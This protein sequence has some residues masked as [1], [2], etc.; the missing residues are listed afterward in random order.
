[1]RLLILSCRSSPMLKYKYIVALSLVSTL[2]CAVLKPVPTD[3]KNCA[4]AEVQALV[5]NAYSEIATALA[6]GSWFSSLES[7]VLKD[8]LD[9]VNCTLQAFI[10]GV[11]NSG[12]AKGSLDP[13]SVLA[14][15]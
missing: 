10:A 6:S 9:V 8:G 14:I 4:S 13:K 2:A 11:T 1:M 7:L 5:S 15:A 3:L 12:K